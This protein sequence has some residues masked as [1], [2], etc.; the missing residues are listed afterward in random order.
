MSTSEQLTKPARQLKSAAIQQAYWQ[1]EKAIEETEIILRELHNAETQ[2][3]EKD[4]QSYSLA[5]L[6]NQMPAM[7]GE[8]RDRILKQNEEL[9]EIL[10]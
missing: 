1:L 9:R 6:L 10:F 3:T 8:C 4:S 7:L 5:D 2:E